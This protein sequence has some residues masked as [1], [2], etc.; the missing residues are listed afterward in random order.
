MHV[1]AEFGGIDWAVVGA[2]FAIVTLVGFLAKREG[3]TKEYFLGNRSMPTWAVAVSL[4]ATML[5][6]VTFI[7]VP[8]A[9]FAGDISYL[10]LN[11]GGFIAVF[12]VGL[13]FVPRLYRA[14]TV[15]IY[16]YLAQR[17]GLGAQ[18]AVSGA[19]IVGRFLSSGARLFAAALPLCLL[20]FGAKAPTFSQ[21]VLAICLIGIVGTVYA[22]AGGVRAVVW[23]DVIQF[24]I[25][26][27]TA[28]LSICML[29]SRMHMSAG[30][31]VDAL[32]HSPN[33]NKLHLV[34]LS[35][36]PL[37]PYTLWAA[38]FGISFLNAA[39]FGVDQD[40]AQRFLITKSASRGTI[41]V[42]ASQ[43]ISI[44]VVSL[45]LCIGLLLYIFYTPEIVGRVHL[46]P[47][48][49]ANVY[50][51]FL[52]NE[53][54]VGLCGLAIAGFF[55]IA[56]GSLDSAMNALASSIVADFYIPLRKRA[57]HEVAEGKASKRTVALVGGMMCL[58]AIFCA[59]IYDPEAHT[60]LDFVQGLMTFAL[61][62]MLG[63]FLTALFTT[64]G[65]SVS[66]IFALL[67]GALTILILQD[68]PMKHWTSF[69]LGRPITLAWPWWTPIGTIVSF[70]VCVAAPPGSPRAS[71][72][73]ERYAEG[74]AAGERAERGGDDGSGGNAV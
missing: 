73:A 4:V 65:N 31:I 26:V 44:A 49:P 2:Y 60:L 37:K 41:S 6:V 28:I 51:W 67:A 59:A 5:S 53:L 74:E 70:A 8:A 46:P 10:I 30:D 66:V 32:V 47:E 57:G 20:L 50:P 15:T 58:F 43:F 42:I 21:L 38:I 52:I 45:F 35:L 63:V 62:G 40:L 48:T 39:A 18:L 19:F 29:L 33:G 1:L 72:A 23:V 22:T 14:G 27:G 12:I 24:V 36:D 68:W 17:F 7:G 9:A 64:R 71:T 16:G 34:D 61:A 69:L 55:A 3:G 25:V 56:Q 11:V 54:P 13:L